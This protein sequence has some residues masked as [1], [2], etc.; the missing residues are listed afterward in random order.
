MTIHFTLQF[1]LILCCELCVSWLFNKC[2]KHLKVI[3]DP[4]SQN[5]DVLSKLLWPW[6]WRSLSVSEFC[7]RVGEEWKLKTWWEMYFHLK[8]TRRPVHF[9]LSL[10]QVRCFWCLHKHPCA[11]ST[12]SC[13]TFI[14]PLRRVSKTHMENCQVSFHMI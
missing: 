5:T 9:F 12:F 1:I 13:R 7:L 14:F 3:T 2:Q 6:R 8:V 11:L 4:Y 10:T